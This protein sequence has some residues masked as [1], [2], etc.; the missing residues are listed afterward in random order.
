L[1]TGGPVHAKIDAVKFVTN[2]FKGG[3]MAKLVDE[4]R[5]QGAEVVYL[6]SKDAKKPRSTK[7][8]L[9][10]PNP[11]ETQGIVV[12]DGFHDYRAKVKEMAPDFDVIIL[13]AAVA[14]LI[15]TGFSSAKHS[16]NACSCVP[17]PLEGKFP[18]HDFKPG[19]KILM[20]WIIAPRIIDEVKA[21]MK[22]GAHLFGF[23]LLKGVE[24]E[25]LV[26]AAYDILLESKATAVFAND[27]TNL[28]TV[29]AI[30][31]DRGQHEMERVWI[32]D[33]IF[34][35]V[36]EEYYRTEVVGGE[37]DGTHWVLLN[38]MADKYRIHYKEKHNG[39]VFGTIACKISQ[40]SFVCT[41]RGK[42][43]LDEIALVESVDHE[44]RIVKSVGKKATLNA[45]LIDHI[46]KTVPNAHYVVHFHDQWEGLRTLPYATPGTVQDS[47][48]D[49]KGSFNVEG[50]GA[51]LIFT[52]G[53][54]KEEPQ[55]IME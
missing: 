51:F 27:A 30:T 35:R 22:K 21:H 29:H 53:T 44:N 19:Q 32:S 45:P 38:D 24:H 23:K 3:L 7:I 40:E 55:M 10:D 31:K 18:S 8:K 11:Q 34:N 26:T 37:L 1:V 28:S 42:R 13:G 52:Q 6:C 39:M 25:E 14:N 17:L 33:F 46:L 4:L 2:H 41:G 48:R 12:H 54:L 49:V 9:N 50:H 5:E 36:S 43:E 16:K 20:E 15:P 47:L